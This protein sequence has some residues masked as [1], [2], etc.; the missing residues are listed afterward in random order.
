MC[1]NQDWFA[2]YQSIDGGKILIGNNVDCKVVGIGSIQIKM[3]DGI[4]RTLIDVRHVPYLWK[5]LISFG[6]LESNGYMYKA[7]G[8][9]MIIFKGSLVVM[10][11]QKQNG[12]Y[13]L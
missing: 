9:I 3:F 13:L 8:G 7:G 4:V 10:K 1:L 6:T 12:L 11:E 5:N 2:T